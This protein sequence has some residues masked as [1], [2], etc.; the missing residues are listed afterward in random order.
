MAGALTFGSGALDVL[1]LMHLGG[2]FASVM[3]G[4]LAL[5]GLGVAR[6]DTSALIHT[7][8]AIVSY[9]IGVAFGSRITGVREP[10]HPVWPTRVT[11]TLAVEFVMLCGLA[12]GW[13]VTGANPGGGAQL[14]LLA[15]AAG[16]MG[17]QGAAMRGLGV[18]VATTFLTGTLTSLVE[19][20]MGA[21]KRRRDSAA[22]ASLGGAVTGAACGGLLLLTLPVVTPVLT[23]VPLAAVLGVAA[24]RHRHGSDS[25][26]EQ[27]E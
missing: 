14:A 7:A 18:A 12:V 9:V 11:V 25:S 15:M 23:L 1:T 4:N 19:G 3:T 26:G 2:V 27:A 5:L 24:H 22:I 13:V 8:A 16:G 17:M 10:D 21:P 6:A 20:L